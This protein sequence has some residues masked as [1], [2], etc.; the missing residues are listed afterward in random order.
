MIDGAV[1]PEPRRT[2][3][4]TWFA[5]EGSPIRGVLDLGTKDADRSLGEHLEHLEASDREGAVS[6]GL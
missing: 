1:E 4:A 2:A 5:R 3:R 6:C